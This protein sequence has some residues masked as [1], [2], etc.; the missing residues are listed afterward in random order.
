M[1]TSIRKNYK[2]T[3]GKFMCKY[4]SMPAGPQAL[5]QLTTKHYVFRQSQS[6]QHLSGEMLAVAMELPTARPPG[7]PAIQLCMHHH[8]RS[9]TPTTSVISSMI[10]DTSQIR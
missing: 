7:K 6:T 9:R 1:V 4:H 10:T 2:H 3:P 8:H 5:K